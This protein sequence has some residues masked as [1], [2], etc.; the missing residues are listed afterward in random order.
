MTLKELTGEPLEAALTQLV[1]EA[2]PAAIPIALDAVDKPDH[3]KWFKSDLTSG[4]LVVGKLVDFGDLSLVFCSPSNNALEHANALLKQVRNQSSRARLFIQG[5]ESHVF[6]TQKLLSD[7]QV[8]KL[9]MLEVLDLVRPPHNVASTATFR[10]LTVCDES[11]ASNLYASD[12][13]NVFSRQ[14]LLRGGYYGLFV[15]KELV[16]ACCVYGYAQIGNAYLL[17]GFITASEQR[18]KGYATELCTRL[19]TETLPPQTGV[20]LHVEDTNHPAMC[21]YRQLGFV[22]A[23]VIL[24]I[25]CIRL[26]AR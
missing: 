3:V 15:G 7:F 13:R 18:R 24:E 19:C 14:Q 6:P 10:E 20:T 9:A 5:F 26:G 22:R 4:Q 2:G 17:G 23:G 1:N 21:L 8:Q 25:D 12:E 16:S 11:S